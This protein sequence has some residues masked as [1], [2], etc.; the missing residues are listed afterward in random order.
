MV[1]VGSTCRSSA[2]ETEMAEHAAALPPPSRDDDADAEFVAIR[3]ALQETARGRRFLEEFARRQRNADTVMVLD[4]VARIEL[5]LAAQPPESIAG[6]AATG[7]A[8]ADLARLVGEGRAALA[9]A[10]E[11]SGPAHEGL[12]AIRDIS[13]MLRE[14]G[15]DLRICDL[16]DRGTGTIDAG[17]AAAS[18]ALDRLSA[19][20][21]A[22]GVH[23][24]AAA[25]LAPMVATP[26]RTAEAQLPVL[27]AG[28]A[29]P[30]L[31]DPA[32]PPAPDPA[33]PAADAAPPKAVQQHDPTPTPALAEL[34]AL[35]DL[36]AA[37]L[38]A[39]LLADGVV[40]LPAPPGGE[41]F[42]AFSCMTQAEK[43][44]FFS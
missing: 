20:I 14:C 10:G 17:L 34:V 3:G 39:V 2:D 35:A 31:A 28:A 23:S 44:A 30:P 21:D 41:P 7:D 26:V 40:T 19:L 18:A 4:A 29:P 16:L 12:S 25:A 42:A 33:P 38:G 22:T 1:I 37:S 24:V 13:H 15:A 36:P 5:R 8:P 6:A 43:L 32:M 9:K 27:P 11:A